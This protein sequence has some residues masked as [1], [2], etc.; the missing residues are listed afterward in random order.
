MKSKCIFNNKKFKSTDTQIK[1]SFFDLLLLTASNSRI[2]LGIIIRNELKWNDQIKSSASKAIQHWLQLNKHLQLG[3]KM[4]RF[5]TLY[6]VW[7][8]RLVPLKVCPAGKHF[9]QI[10][11]LSNGM[12]LPS[13]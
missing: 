3:I 6:P 4:F 13:I 10:E 5:K 8:G 1:I 9:L 7:N 11:Q 12:N 2:N